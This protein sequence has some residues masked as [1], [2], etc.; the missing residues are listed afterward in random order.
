MDSTYAKR[1][2]DLEFNSLEVLWLELKINRKKALY[3][4]L[5]VYTS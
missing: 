1:R 5:Y 2:S 3:G 4:T